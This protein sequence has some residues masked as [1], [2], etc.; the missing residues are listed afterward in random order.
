MTNKKHRA[1]IQWDKDRNNVFK[2]IE[3]ETV[4][5]LWGIRKNKINMNYDKLGRALRLYY[6]SAN[7]QGNGILSKMDNEKFTYKFEIDLNEVIGCN[8][9]EM[10]KMV[11]D[12]QGNKRT[13]RFRKAVPKELNIF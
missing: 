6:P 5:N 4:A 1:F 13:R 9:K 3:P 10:F 7:V 12:I 2:F 8:S 11:N